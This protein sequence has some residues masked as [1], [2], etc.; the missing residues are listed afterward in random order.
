MLS[1]HFLANVLPVLRIEPIR[2]SLM[3]AVT[4]KNSGHRLKVLAE[5]VYSDITDAK[6]R[7]TI[8]FMKFLEAIP[9]NLRIKE[10]GITHYRAAVGR[11][12]MLHE[13]LHN[14]KI[15]QS[16]PSISKVDCSV[17]PQLREISEKINSLTFKP[18]ESIQKN[19]NKSVEISPKHLPHLML[20]KRKFSNKQYTKQFSPQNSIEK[21]YNYLSVVLKMWP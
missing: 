18:K 13:I 12:E 14:E 21:I 20:Y 5:T 15:L 1:F 11:A 8:Q 6:N 17:E 3:P 16:I 2:L 10:E 7:D 19:V 9:S 4:I